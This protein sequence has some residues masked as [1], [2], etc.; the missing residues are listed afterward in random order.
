MTEEDFEIPSS[1][2]NTGARN[3][4]SYGPSGSYRQRQ[5]WNEEGRRVMQQSFLRGLAKFESKVVSKVRSSHQPGSRWVSDKESVNAN[6]DQPPDTGAS[7]DLDKIRQKIKGHQYQTVIEL[8]GDLRSAWKK[9]ESQITAEEFGECEALFDRELEKAMTEFPAFSSLGYSQQTNRCEAS[10]ERLDDCGNVFVARM[11]TGKSNAKAEDSLPGILKQKGSYWSSTEENEFPRLLKLYGRDFPK[12][13]EYLMTKSRSDVE[14]HFQDLV[15]SGREDLSQLVTAAEIKFRSETDR[16]LDG[17][18]VN[19]DPSAELAMTMPPHQELDCAGAHDMR[20]YPSSLG[21]MRSQNSSLRT[22]TPSIGSEAA[23]NSVTPTSSME[24]SSGPKRYKRRPPPKA[25]CPHCT[26]YP[27]GLHN[28]NALAKHI[29]RFHLPM[30]RVWRCRDVSINKDF[31]ANCK[32]CRRNKRYSFKKAAVDHLRQKH[33][34]ASTP[35]EKLQKWVMEVEEPNPQY[36]T[37]AMSL[38]SI[39]DTAALPGPWRLQESWH[40]KEIPTSNGANLHDGNVEVSDSRS[41]ELDSREASFHASEEEEMMPESGIPGVCSFGEVILS[42]VSFDNILPGFP[43]D[44]QKNMS[45]GDR[46]AE[47]APHLAN[48][49][50]IRVYQ[51]D[52]LPHLTSFQKEACKD[53]VEALYEILDKDQVGSKTYNAALDSLESL[54]R[55]LLKDLR[56]WRQLSTFAP[57]LPVSV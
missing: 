17:M 46:P 50:F 2:E 30:R 5:C 16:S 3:S 37:N 35:A 42:D 20:S 48:R 13:S 29:S 33:F 39:Q 22:F 4:K 9:S 51:V 49:G 40:S 55:T 11:E 32:P 38:N 15:S 44:L 24:E 6:L 10:L 1:L 31:L 45:S 56:D 19:V 36:Q 28:D 14:Q 53:H 12:I 27:D 26:K 43:N 54:S 34:P 23:E 18:A 47:I 7:I 41:P 57:Q 52:K 8:K 21:E 25:F